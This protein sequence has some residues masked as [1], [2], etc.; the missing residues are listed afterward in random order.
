MINPHV[1][2]IIIKGEEN[3]V[4]VL[5]PSASSPQLTFDSAGSW[6]HRLSR[7]CGI[8]DEDGQVE[9]ESVTN[10]LKLLKEH[11]TWKQIINVNAMV[12]LMVM[13]FLCG[14]YH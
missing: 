14:V 13:V 7:L 11:P 12:G 2:I 1:C 10:R 8:E 9:E 5:V 3:T 4:P 6:N